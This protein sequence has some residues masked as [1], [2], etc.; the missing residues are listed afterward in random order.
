MYFL[1]ENV[2]L[3]V[4]EKVERAFGV[5]QGL[6]HVFNEGVKPR[7][8]AFFT[9][10]VFPVRSNTFFGDVVHLAAADLYLD[11]SSLRTHDSDM[12]CFVAIWLRLL[13]PVTNSSGVVFVNVCNQRH[14][15]VAGFTCLVVGHVVGMVEY[16]S[17]GKQ[18][19]HI[20]ERYVLLLHL[21][22]D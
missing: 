1:G 8:V 3:E 15:P 12:Q 9:S 18:V 13:H 11:P 20:F 4:V 7:I 5:A 6:L 17:Y 22:P 10:F 2:E 21:V 16:D 14:Y 19:V